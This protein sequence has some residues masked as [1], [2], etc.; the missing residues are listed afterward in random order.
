MAR[1]IKMTV[2]G[3]PRI[4]RIGSAKG[5]VPESE[6][7][8]ETIRERLLLTG[9]KRPCNEGGCG[10]CTVLVDGKPTLSCSTLT[11]E[12]D[13]RSVLT[14]EGLADPATGELHP[15]QQAFVELDAI[16]CGMCT[17]G[18]T[19]TAKALLDRNPDPTRQE[20]AE[21]LAGNICRCTGY[22]KYF[23]GILLAAK[24]MREAKAQEKGV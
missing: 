2:N 1:E 17:P 14:I 3:K 15:I 12:C 6:T 19:L 4:F 22:E 9:T 16:Q 10:G 7:L 8:V 21:A 13:G 5:E 24:R 18:I 23:D 11:V 20:V